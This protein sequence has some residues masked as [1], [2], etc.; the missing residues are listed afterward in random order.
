MGEIQL[1]L[2]EIIQRGPSHPVPQ[3]IDQPDRIAKIPEIETFKRGNLVFGKPIFPGGRKKV[4]MILPI[5]ARKS[6]EQVLE[7]DPDTSLFLEEWSHVEANPHLEV[8]Y[9]LSREMSRESLH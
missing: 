8:M 3:G 4:I 9:S 6:K 1:G 7:I 5:E 2:D